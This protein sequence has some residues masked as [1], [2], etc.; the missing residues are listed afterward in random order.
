MRQ[1]RWTAAGPRA[2][3]YA[4]TKAAV[5]KLQ[6]MPQWNL[7]PITSVWL[8]LHRGIRML[9]GKRAI[10]GLKRLKNLPM[11]RFATTKE[12]AAGVLYL[13]S[14]EAA[15]MTGSMLTIDGGATLPVTAA[16]DFE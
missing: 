8:P 14:D 4:P 10:L 9:V 3:I 11:R 5:A 7:Y 6:K 2:T 1:I 16:N 15:Y 13:I 12:I